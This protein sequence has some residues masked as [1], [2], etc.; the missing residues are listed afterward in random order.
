[1]PT[2]DGPLTKVSTGQPF[3]ARAD[4]WNLFIDAALENQ[5]R[6]YPNNFGEDNVLYNNTV[7][8][9]GYNETGTALD[10]GAIVGI[11][12]PIFDVATAPQDFKETIG[13]EFVTPVVPDHDN[14]WAVVMDGSPALDFVQCAIGGLVWVLVDV[15]D[16]NHMFATPTDS[17]TLHL[18]SSDA[19]APIA[20]K[21]SGT[22][23][24]NAMVLLK[25]STASPL[26]I[27]EIYDNLKAP[28]EPVESD[29]SCVFEARVLEI[30]SPNCSGGGWTP[31]AMCWAFPIDDPSG[32]I[33]NRA[34]FIGKKEGTYDGG[35][36]ERDLYEIAKGSNVGIVRFQTTSSKAYGAHVDAVTV[37]WDGMDYVSTTN[38]VKIL[39]TY[40]I[41]GAAAAGARGMAISRADRPEV[42]SLPAYEILFIEQRPTMFIG[43]AN[44]DYQK[45]S[46]PFYGTLLVD[47][48]NYDFGGGA[49]EPR[50]GF[51][52]N[53]QFLPGGSIT[54]YDASGA[55]QAFRY[56]KQGDLVQLDYFA[57][58]NEYFISG[59]IQAQ[60]KLFWGALSTKMQRD[61]A[62]A[63]GVSLNALIE[64]PFNRIDL[65]PN[66]PMNVFNLA[67]EAGD[68]ILVARVIQHLNDAEEYWIIQITHKLIDATTTLSV[69]SQ[70]LLRDH[71]MVAVPYSEDEE[72]EIISLPVGGIGGSWVVN[73][74]TGVAQQ[75]DVGAPGIRDQVNYI[76]S[77]IGT[78]T[79]PGQ[80]IQTEVFNVSATE[81]TVLISHANGPTVNDT[82]NHASADDLHDIP[83]QIKY[84]SCGHPNEVQWQTP[85]HWFEKWLE[86]AFNAAQLLTGEKC[87]LVFTATSDYPNPDV[88]CSVIKLSDCPT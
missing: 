42:D 85:C 87:V 70:D 23:V 31:G 46:A 18:T 68:N 35:M 11:D 50:S 9:R 40:S 54:C 86:E 67:G 13:F 63:T 52:L 79:T 26:A 1:M 53:D 6:D 72:Q 82:L 28:G 56:I 21:E 61:D 65:V 73:A 51:A 38:A 37:E 66:N 80:C 60:A 41:F 5:Q 20:W 75:V 62:T 57:P 25:G 32:T 77:W 22:G 24:K 10:K 4:T 69:Q 78:P 55:N 2:N 17:N 59:L 36:D 71:R 88:T 43:R 30:S 74:G 29:G 64:G 47:V 15:K 27:I 83:V 49:T 44:S 34:R 81:H 14:A 7:R 48:V 19:G 33:P 45:Q 39:D 12:A 3:Q 16:E 76:G 84:D 58:T 8:V